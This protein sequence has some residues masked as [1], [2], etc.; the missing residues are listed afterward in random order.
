MF[1]ELQD[2]ISAGSTAPARFDAAAF[3]DCSA[4]A[5]LGG[6]APDT[7]T[8]ATPLLKQCVRLPPCRPPPTRSG[9]TWRRWQI[10]GCDF[11]AANQIATGTCGT[12]CHL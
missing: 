4:E 6:P 10:W 1:Q 5:G 11:S 12:S 3:A 9:F 8:Q 7:R 2:L